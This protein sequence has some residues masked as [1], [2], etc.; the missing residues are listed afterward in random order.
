MVSLFRLNTVQ[1]LQRALDI[2]RDLQKTN[3]LN[4]TDEK[5]IAEAERRIQRAKSAGT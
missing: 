1:H 5:W 3:T 2:L 4:P